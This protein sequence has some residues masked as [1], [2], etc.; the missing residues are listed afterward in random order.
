MRTCTASSRRGWARSWASSRARAT[1]AA[2]ATSRR[3][4]RCASG[5][6]RPST[7]CGT[8][9]R[10]LVEALVAQGLAGADAVMPGYTHTR[11]AEPITLRPPRWPP[12]PGA[13]CATTSGCGDARAPGGRAAPRLRAPSPAPPCP[14]TARPSPASSA[15]RRSRANALDAVIDR[16]FAA[17]FVFA[18]AQ[19]ADAPLAPRRGPH[20]ALGPGV[21]LLRAARGLHHRLEPHAAEEEPGRARARA[22][23]GGARGRRP[24][25]AC[26][27]LMKG[28]PAGYQKDLQEDKEAVF[29]A[30]DTAMGS[31]AVMAGVVAGLVAHRETMARAAAGE[32]HDGG[33]P[34]RRPR[35]RGHAVPQGARPGGDARGRGARG[36]GPRCA[37]SPR[38]RSPTVSP[39]VAA[40]LGALFDPAE[41]VRAKA[42]P[43]GT[44]PAAVR[45]SLEAARAR[46]RSGA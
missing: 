11:A 15:S 26:S 38:K 17:E 44:A 7:A 2:A 28:L 22:R 6:A 10:A 41:A 24:R 29:D 12:T 31:V 34:R 46:V 23:Q 42:A 20:L 37:T 19:L 33:R 13:S 39:A 25:C 40:R 21:R 45:A 18:C 27:S 35:P 36:P 14:S 5:S 9:V 30:A 16:D 1:S 8:A 43:G 32:E 3:S 4:P